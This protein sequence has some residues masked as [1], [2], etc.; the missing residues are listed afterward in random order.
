VT[1]SLLAGLLG[2]RSIAAAGDAAGTAAFAGFA[3]FFIAIWV[4]SIA[5][6]VF[7][8]VKL[9][10]VCKIPE[11]QFRIAGSEKTSWILVVA[12]AQAIGALI[13]HFSGRRKAVL[14]AAA[15]LGMAPPGWY[16]DPFA[17]GYRWWD[18]RQWG[19]PAPG[20]PAPGTPTS[21]K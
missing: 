13:W 17:P 1:S 21:P 9:V 5:G 7:W 19:Q 2:A 3:F 15:Q 6:L 12:L 20:Q 14:A 10:E 18:G 11:A 4:L 16:P 8:I